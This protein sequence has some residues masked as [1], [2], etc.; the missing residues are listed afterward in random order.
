MIIYGRNSVFEAINEN[1]KI[2]RIFIDKNK[3]N[4]FVNLIKSANELKIPQ[5]FV[6][7]KE[8]E[9]IS[10]SRKHQGICAELT[11]PEEIIEDEN[12][13]EMN[14]SIKKI[15]V[16]D[17]ITDTGNLG[18]ITRSALLF[19]CDLII[20]PKD[21]SAR[22]TPQTIKAS[23]GAI[24]KQ[25][26]LYVNNLNSWLFK[27]KEEG[28]KIIGFSVDG[29]SNLLEVEKPEKIVCVIGSEHKGLRKSTKRL[30]DKLV[31]IPT[32]KKIDSLNASVASAI[33]MWELF[34]KN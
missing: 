5:S 3:K 14:E 12:H 4:K 17:G 27:I 19:G 15:L 22:I 29:L 21:N 11:L 10:H 1:I 26:L 24:Y 18:A 9:K 16:L 25:K 20:L 23:A 30:C 31:S 6:D 32:T 28:F 8:I 2:K 34:F 33:V 13:F 7:E